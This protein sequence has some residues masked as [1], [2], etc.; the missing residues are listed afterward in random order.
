MMTEMLVE[1]MRKW[2][3]GEGKCD[4]P[5]V[6]GISGGKDSSVVAALLVKALGKENVLGVLMPNGTQ[7]DIGDSHDLC[8]VLGLY[9]ITVDI[10]DAVAGLVD[11]IPV[12]S[13]FKL[14]SDLSR[15][16]TNIPPRIR[17]TALYAVAQ[18][19]GGRV[20]N[21]TNAAEAYVGYG[22]LFGDTCGDF[23]PIRNLFVDEV[24]DLGLA[25]GLPK[26]F[27]EKPP[28]DGLTGKTDEEVLGFT[29][30]DVKKV[31]LDLKPRSIKPESE[32]AIRSKHMESEFKRKILNVPSIDFHRDQYGDI[33]DIK[34]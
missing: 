14:A 1:K 34:D 28:A 21:T 5:V 17:M 12:F 30:A 16:S 10:Q 29:Y 2:R 11:A 19:Y 4:G 18:R 15:F 13:H 20:I 32:L 27:V 9:N 6:L 26:R 7:A 8:N 23:A 3:I 31:A 25:L 33:L 24:I 22:T